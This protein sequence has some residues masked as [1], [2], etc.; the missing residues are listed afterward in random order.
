[1]TDKEFDAVMAGPPALEGANCI[2]IAGE[3]N[4]DVQGDGHKADVRN[5]VG[6]AEGAYR[7]KAR[8][9]AGSMQEACER[10]GLKEKNALQ[11][12]TFTAASHAFE[13]LASEKVMTEIF[14][15][16]DENKDGQ[17]S[18]EECYLHVDTF[19]KQLVAV[20][21]VRNLFCDS[22]ADSNQKLSEEEFADFGR[23]LDPHSSGAK[24]VAFFQDALDKNKDYFVDL[25]EIN[26][27]AGITN[28]SQAGSR[29]DTGGMSEED[30]DKYAK[31]PAILQGVARVFVKGV[32]PQAVVQASAKVKAVF[33]VVMKNALNISV[34][35]ASV[36]ALPQKGEFKPLVMLFTARAADGQA[37]LKLLRSQAM[38]IRKKIEAAEAMV[39]G[40]GAKA[41]VWSQVTFDFYGPKAAKLPKGQRK[42]IQKWGQIP[43]MPADTSS[44]PPALARVPAAGTK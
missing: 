15:Q 25:A 22:D 2:T 4:C 30:L 8:Q 10:M 18:P 17:I 14:K 34:N 21:S 9:W 6:G 26:R 3:L 16:M 44:G 38:A 40:H 31:V 20:K 33:G 24:Y 32:S 29:E 36:Q 28:A 43:G 13:Q 19:R 7:A 35:M 5:I 23:K 12:S 1:L 41:I 39:I 42:I 37:P 11:Q 27:V